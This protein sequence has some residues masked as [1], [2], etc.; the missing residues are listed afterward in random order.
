MSIRVH[1]M[2]SLNHTHAHVHTHT[3]T[4]TQSKFFF[5]NPQRIVFMNC[6]HTILLIGLF[7]AHYYYVAIKDK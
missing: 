5:V 7:L 2:Q 6:L 4:H 1:Y 3:R